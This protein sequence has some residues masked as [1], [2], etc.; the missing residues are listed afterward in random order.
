M[1]KKTRN[2]YVCPF[3]FRY[4]EKCICNTYSMS[5]ILVD[6]N[7]QSIIKKLNDIGY[8]TIDCCEGHFNN[9]KP[10]IYISF[11]K[12]IST[13]PKGF[14]LEDNKIIRHFYKATTKEEFEKEKQ[15]MINN[16][17]KWIEEME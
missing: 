11:V 14:K 13:A 12:K 10:N 15:Q 1:S 7:L 6:Y 17:K 4:P 16:I 5:L 9:Y 3:C 2:D 8:K